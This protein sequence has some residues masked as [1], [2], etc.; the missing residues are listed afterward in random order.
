MAS[1]LTNTYCTKHV[2]VRYK[3]VNEYVK[4]RVVEVVFVKSACNDSNI[5]T[6]TIS[7][8]LHEKHSRK[9]VGLRCF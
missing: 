7:R 1:N 4:E 2:D 5:L 8:E 9:M 3:Y 6:K